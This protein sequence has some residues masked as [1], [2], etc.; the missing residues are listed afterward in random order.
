MN[1]ID[2]VGDWKSNDEWR[3]ADKEAAW[4]FFFAAGK[5]SSQT[6]IS[7]QCVKMSQY[8]SI[9]FELRKQL[10]A[11]L[12][13]EVMQLREIIEKL[14]VVIDDI[15]T[16]SDMAKADDKLYRSLVERRQKDRW[17]TRINCDG[18][19]LE[20]PTQFTPTA[21]NELIEKVEKR[22]IQRCSVAA[23]KAYA[24]DEVIAAIRKL[25]EQ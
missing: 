3:Y 21:L 10:A 7:A 20:F 5:E 4:K 24:T 8:E 19:K 6:V 13:A 17:G 9:I 14:W 2:A 22:T 23:D 12:E 18:Y 16:Y 1:F 25:G 15:D 11:A